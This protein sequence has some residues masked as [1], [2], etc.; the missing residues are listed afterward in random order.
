GQSRYA[1]LEN[2]AVVF[3]NS[4]F[5]TRAVGRFEELADAHGAVG[6]DSPRQLDPEFVFFPNFAETGFAMGFPR[7]IE[8]LPFLLE[9]DT[10][11][12]LA[13]TDPSCGMS[14]L[15]EQIMPLRCKTH[16]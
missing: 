8:S 4:E 5:L 3:F 13:E 2:P 7:G 10:H 1:I 6:I 14:F 9:C 12:R 16:R 15:A 11:H